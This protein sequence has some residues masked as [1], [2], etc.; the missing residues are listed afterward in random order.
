MAHGDLGEIVQHGLGDFL[1]QSQGNG[2]PQH[3]GLGNDANNAAF[4]LTHIAGDAFGQELHHLNRDGHIFKASP[5]LDDF[6]PGLEIRAVNGCH[7]K[8]GQS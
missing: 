4:E 6:Y 3:A 7:Q 1:G 5:A 8:A 2:D